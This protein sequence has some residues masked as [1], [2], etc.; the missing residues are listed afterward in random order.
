MPTG[1]CTVTADL[2]VGL[3]DVAVADAHH[4]KYIYSLA[5][6]P[7]SPSIINT[8]ALIPYSILA[9]TVTIQYGTL[10]APSTGS[11]TYL[12]TQRFRI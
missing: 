6:P 8:I 4:D 1:C 2:H 3:T 11:D 7:S 10:P 9:K 12:L 5:T